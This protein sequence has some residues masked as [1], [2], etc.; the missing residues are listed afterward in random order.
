[1]LRLIFTV[2]AVITGSSAVYFYIFHQRLSSRIQHQSRHGKLSQ[3]PG[4]IESAPDSV[5]TDEYFTLYD[6]SL[7]AT[8][9]ASL[10]S[11]VPTELLFTKLVRRNMTAFSHFPQALILRALSKAPE[12]RKSF[13]ASHISSL[14][15]SEGDLIC[16]VYR[17]VLRNKNKVE[18][19]I[20]MK[21]MPWVSGRLVISFQERGDEV[22]FSTET[23][24]W[25]RADEGR[26]MPLE[27]PV[28]RWMHETAA[29]WLIDS[30][31]GYLV[32][33]D[34]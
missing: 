12:E 21:N 24:M 1:M 11:G 2:T 30:G 9:R 14:D 6:R 22:L 23:L 8:L 25:R 10:P 4:N 18:L 15:F 34:S 32:D 7:K 17:V 13:T 29:W 33:L 26:R 3:K 27:K 5:I 20:K 16:G 28:V 19:E 31:V